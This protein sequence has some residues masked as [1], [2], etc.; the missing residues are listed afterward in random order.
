MNYKIEGGNLPVLLCQL[1]AG[2]QMMCEGGSMS[3]MDDEIEMKTQG[4]GIGKMF[5]KM[6]TGEKLFQ[7]IYVA[8]RPGEIAFASSF[9]GS[10]RA[11][12]V[13]PDKPVVAQKSAF[14]ASYGDIEIS[15]F[16]QKKLKAGIFGGEG[17]L[18]QKFSGN[19][20]VFI[21][22]D[23]S[24]VEYDI[25]AGDCKIVDT[26]YLA[27]MDASCS[28]DTRTVKGAKNV[29]FGGEGLFNTVVNGPGHI[30]V[31]TMPIQK[32]AMA[33]DPYITK[34]TTSSN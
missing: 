18:M 23:G 8:N 33:I 19:G 15:V 30:I 29:L 25:P 10:I 11:I 24:A 31:Q 13:T 12:E 17:F 1:E 9:P 3:W 28:I 4:G 5:G 20:I 2:E 26:G 6:L 21:E 7:N 14:L 34:T 16:F 32:T 27:A 22:I